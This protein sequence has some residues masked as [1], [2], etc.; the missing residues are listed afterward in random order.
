MNADQNG[1]KID[2][3]HIASKFSNVPTLTIKK[4]DPTEV[5]K[6]L[7]TINPKKATGCDLIP[8]RVVQQSAEVLCYP[9]ATLFN[10]VLDAGKIPRQWKLGEIT[11]LYKKI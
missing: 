3:N 4:T 1:Q 7:N 6:V 5:K 9:F 11:P 2:L 10:Y 8:P